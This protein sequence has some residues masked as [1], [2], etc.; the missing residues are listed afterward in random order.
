MFSFVLPTMLVALGLISIRQSRAMTPERVSTPAGAGGATRAD[1]VRQQA[2]SVQPHGTV[3]LCVFSA[4]VLAVLERPS[5]LLWGAAGVV[6]VLVGV[7]TRR[8]ARR[9]NVGGVVRT[10][11]EAHRRRRTLRL[12]LLAA[13]LMGAGKVAMVAGQRGADLG[14]QGLGTAGVAAA[15]VVLLA[16]GWSSVWV[17]SASTPTSP[18]TTRRSRSRREGHDAASDASAPR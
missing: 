9:L 14:L 2:D 12:C 6:H 3:L 13:L 16:A 5:A 10:A 8:T 4:A 18:V 15:V 17:M 1:V 11:P 7:T